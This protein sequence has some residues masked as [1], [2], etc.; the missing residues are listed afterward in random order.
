M[1]RITSRLALGIF[2]VVAGVATSLAIA[3]YPRALNA[4]AWVAHIAA[5][6]FV[7][8][9]MSIVAAEFKRS[10]LRR[11]FVGAILVALLSVGT[12]IALGPGLR[13]CS[14]VLSWLVMLAPE[15]ACRFVFA[16]GA[17]LIGGMIAWFIASARSVD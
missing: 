9:G 14:L 5:F 13:R 1:I 10:N 17:L 6:T 16:I 3:S 7:L 11:W 4:P 2:A 8:T 12:W 15:L